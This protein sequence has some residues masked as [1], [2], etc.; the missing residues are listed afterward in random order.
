MK[1]DSNIRMLTRVYQKIHKAME[2]TIP[3]ITPSGKQKPE[4]W[5]NNRLYNMRNKVTNLRRQY[6]RKKS[7]RNLQMYI[8]KTTEY[9]ALCTETKEAE[10][11]DFLETL[12]D[13][14]SLSNFHKAITK[15]K[16]PQINSLLKNTWDRHSKDADK[17]TL[18]GTK[19]TNGHYIL[20]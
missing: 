1:E 12:P 4:T 7:E 5:F 13:I 6:N 17:K 9:K 18:S 14:Q 3:L 8:D 10:F 11:K 19:T 15:Q 20:E 16:P 2:K